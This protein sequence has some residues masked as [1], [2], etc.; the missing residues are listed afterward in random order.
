M[1][2]L[3]SGFQ[4]VLGGGGSG[5]NETPTPAD[6]IERLV[7]RLVSSTLLVSNPCCLDISGLSEMKLV[8]PVM[9]NYRRGLHSY[10]GA[11]TKTSLDVCLTE[12]KH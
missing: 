12:L 6:T 5:A 7:D 2:I 9:D 4:S 3:R 11:G 8:L 10:L 1:E